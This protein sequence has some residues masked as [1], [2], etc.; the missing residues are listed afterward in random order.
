MGGRGKV[1]ILCMLQ[2]WETSFDDSFT[3]HVCTLWVIV[4]SCPFEDM[5]EKYP[6]LTVGTLDCCKTSIPLNLDTYSWRVRSASS[7]ASPIPCCLPAT[8]QIPLQPAERGGM[9]G[10][11]ELLAAAANIIWGSA[12]R[13]KATDF[14]MGGS[15]ASVWWDG[16][17][18]IPKRLWEGQSS[19]SVW[20]GL[21]AFLFPCG[22]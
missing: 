4:F 6:L 16:T 9:A 7:L 18:V 2:Q 15:P 1:S 20:T 5:Q 10:A 19:S 22:V 3:L 8:A 14:S 17:C 13:R 12:E 21:Q 11:R